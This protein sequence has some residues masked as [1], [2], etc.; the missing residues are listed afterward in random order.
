MNKFKFDGGSILVNGTF[1]GA[2][3]GPLIRLY[4]QEN[5]ALHKNIIEKHVVL[6]LEY[7]QSLDQFL[8]EIMLFALQSKKYLVFKKS[9]KFSKF[10]FVIFSSFACIYL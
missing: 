4:G 3:F 7:F 2:G 9:P 10:I 8:R 5:V 6:S 1:S